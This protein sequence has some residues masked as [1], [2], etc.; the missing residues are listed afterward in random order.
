MPPELLTAGRVELC[1][2]PVSDP[3]SGT[4]DVGRSQSPRNSPLNYRIRQKASMEFG[5][6]SA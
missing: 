1:P 6:Y 5:M 2:R 3:T 4:Y